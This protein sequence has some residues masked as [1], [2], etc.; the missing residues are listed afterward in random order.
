MQTPIDFFQ[1][2]CEK[3]LDSL[4]KMINIHYDS[5]SFSHEMKDC[6]KYLG[7][8]LYDHFMFKTNFES[9]FDT[10]SPF[11]LEQAI[12]TGSMSEGLFL[13][14]TEAPDMDFMCVLKNITFSQ[15]D[16]KDGSL[17]LREDTPFVY[18]FVTD[19]KTQYTWKEY[20]D[21]ADKQER[22]HRLSSNKLKEKLEENY[23]KTGGL[24][25]TFGKEELAKVTEGAAVTIRKTKP[26]VQPS[27]VR[28]TEVAKEFLRQPINEPYRIDEVFHA[29]MMNAM[30]DNL[31][32]SS[33]LVLSIFCEGWPACAREW[34]TRERLWAG[35]TYRAENHTKWISYCP[36]EL[37][38]WRFSFVF[39][40]C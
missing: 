15:K 21:A 14:S 16:Q 33:D 9:Y 12:L 36:K 11:Q 37:P 10:Q 18:A 34:I 40:V 28:V 25:R 30:V 5:T 31:I 26:V 6:F 32:P 22:N 29:Q 17:L 35:Y 39:F 23:Q 38:G 7:E 8:H 27:F 3:I 1:K 2:N 20:F 4:L 24:F 19:R 13:Y